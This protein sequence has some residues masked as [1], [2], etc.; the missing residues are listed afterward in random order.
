MDYLP[1]YNN[2]DGLPLDNEHGLWKYYHPVQVLAK[3]MCNRILFMLFLIL[4][5]YLNSV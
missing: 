4:K 2:K 1:L 5:C 3:Y